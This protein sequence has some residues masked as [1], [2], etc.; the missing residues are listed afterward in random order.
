MTF[1][2]TV[3]IDDRED[4][5]LERL[6]SEHRKLVTEARKLS[7]EERKLKTE[8]FSIRCS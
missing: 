5:E 6:V 4:I 3:R 7:A 1:G 8:A 2:V